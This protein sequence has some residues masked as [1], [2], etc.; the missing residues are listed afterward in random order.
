M[1]ITDGDGEPEVGESGQNPATHS[2]TV[3]RRAKWDRERLADDWTY[4]TLACRC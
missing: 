4:H 3:T 1:P 2:R